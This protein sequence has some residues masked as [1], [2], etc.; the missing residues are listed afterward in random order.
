VSAAAREAIATI[1]NG[2]PD[3]AVVVIGPLWPD[4][5]PPAG[6]RNNR[7]VIRAAAETAAVPFVDPLAE[8]WLTDGTG[9]V[10]EDDVHLTDAGQAV[11]ADLVQPVVATAL[12]QAATADPGG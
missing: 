12:D 6:V 9:L 3:A 4:G 2:A 8:G 1:R 10:G 5:S 11:L 7:D